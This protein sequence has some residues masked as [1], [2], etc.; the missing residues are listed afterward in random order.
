VSDPLETPPYDVPEDDGDLLAACDVETFRSGGP[1]GQHQNVTDSG[2]RL[3]HRASGVVVTSRAR[4]SQYQNKQECL[5]RL[6]RRLEKLNAPPPPPRAP[7]KPSR[8]AVQRRLDEKT[9]RGAAKRLRRP[10]AADD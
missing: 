4:R 10:P 5:R 6:R 1:G 8:A 3:R 7:T 2:V 9:R